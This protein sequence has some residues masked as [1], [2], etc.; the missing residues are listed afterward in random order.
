MGKCT[1]TKKFEEKLTYILVEKVKI[2]S[3]KVLKISSK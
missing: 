1:K 2:L 3:R